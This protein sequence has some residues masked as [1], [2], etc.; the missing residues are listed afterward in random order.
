[1]TDS[2]IAYREDTGEIVRV[3]SSQFLRNI[4]QAA[5]VKVVS[6]GWYMKRINPRVC[7]RRY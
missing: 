1:M 4:R 3:A 5:G 6:Y 7:E 2:Y